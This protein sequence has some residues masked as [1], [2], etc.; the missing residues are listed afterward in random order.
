MGLL[1]LWEYKESREKL[2]LGVEDYKYYCK[3]VISEQ[4]LEGSLKFQG[5]GTMEKRKK[6]EEL[7]HHCIS[8]NRTE[9]GRGDNCMA[10][11]RLCPPRFLTMP[12]NAFI[13]ST[14]ILH[15]YHLPSAI[16]LGHVNTIKIKPKIPVLTELTSNW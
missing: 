11:I 10:G 4:I 9:G 14:N 7:R 3:V 8:Q 5:A 1:I 15:L 16:I 2:G 12:Q 6:T 13:H